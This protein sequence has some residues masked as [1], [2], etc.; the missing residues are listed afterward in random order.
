MCEQK[1]KKTK[2]GK[3]ERFA[4]IFDKPIVLVHKWSEFMVWLIVA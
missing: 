2:M 3:S 4:H 1:N